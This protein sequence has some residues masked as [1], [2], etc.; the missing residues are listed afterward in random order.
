MTTETKAVTSTCAK[1]TYW[2]AQEPD[3][4][5][6]RRQP[7]QAISFKVDSET[8]FETRFPETAATDWCGEFKAQ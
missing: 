5:E 8:K 6:C 3:Q 2:N 1:C 7:P 4:G